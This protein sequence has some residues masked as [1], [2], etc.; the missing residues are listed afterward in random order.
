MKNSF[1]LFFTAGLI[2]SFALAAKASVLWSIGEAD[3]TSADLALGTDRP[4]LSY[5]KAFQTDPL[6]I[7]GKSTAA[8]DWPAIQ[9][10][11]SE[12]WAGS[13][14]HRF[15]IAFALQGTVT[16]TCRLVI[17]LVDAAS[18][19]VSPI[20]VSVNNNSLPVQ[21]PAPGNGD[22]TLANHPEAG[23]H[24]SLVFEFPGQDLRAGLN[25][26]TIETQSGSW[27][28]YDAVHLEAPDGAV[29]T[30]TTGVFL[31]PVMTDNS[32]TGP[33]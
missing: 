29:L 19:R 22:A 8:H 6:F 10:G 27:M 15:S 31:G 21:R 16:G 23:H 24:Q 1:G 5:A 9:P 2:F 26:I 4:N 20:I 12:P 11:E 3:Q 7:V 30:E 25:L 14:S 18:K 33:R 13:Q 32:L 28:L 17:D